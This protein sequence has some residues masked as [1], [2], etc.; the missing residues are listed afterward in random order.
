MRET[1]AWRYINRDVVPFAAMIAVE[2]V[3]V[4]STTL[5]KAAASRGLSFYVFVFYSYVVSTLV[6]LPL[7]LIFGRSTRLPSAKSP[8]FF[9]IFLLAVLGFM[10]MI[11]GCKGVEYSSPT[12]ASA[13]STLTP[14]FTFTLAIVF[15]MERVRLTSSASQAKII[16]TVVS[17]S[18]ALVVVLYKGPKLLAPSHYHNLTLSQSSW[19]LGGILLAAQYL[20]ISVWLII[21]T[22]IMEVYSQE[23]T[24]VFLYSLCGTLISAPVCMFAEKDLT[25]FLLKPDV[26]L[27]SIMYTGALVSSLGTVIHTW[28]LHLKGPVYISLFKPLSIVIAVG[29][30]AIFL[31]DSLHLG[32]VIGSVVLSLGFY[33]VVWGKAREDASK[34]VTGSEINSPLLLAHTV[35]YEEA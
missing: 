1:V 22:R 9:K 31:G 2:C 28:G 19:I 6:L 5:Y 29:M 27:V 10:S 7:S 4:G 3:T 35:E 34:P 15:R 23:I 26:S 25:S 21:Q 24:V 18:G 12:L 14:A 32:S 16:G 11:A 30:S 33:T 17:M 13:I 8:V 20:L